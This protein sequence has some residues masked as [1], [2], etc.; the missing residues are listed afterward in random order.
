MWAS[1][2]SIVAC[3]LQSR[4]WGVAVASKF[5]A[6]G[7]LS[8]WAEPEVGAI[9]TQ[10]W[11]RAA[12]GE[13]GLELLRNGYSAQDTVQRLVNADDGRDQRQVG[14]VD[15]SGGAASHT[16]ARC[17]AA[18]HSRLGEGYAAQGNLLA[19][20]E[21]IDAMAETFES[22]ADR[23]F[24]MR[25][26][27]CVDAAQAKGGD[28]RGQQAASLRVVRQGGGYGE[29]NVSVDLRVD[30]HEQPLTE[31]RRL[32]D[33]H[34]LYFGST[35]DEEWL[36]VD[37]G[38]HDE[39]RTALEGLGYASGDLVEDLETWAGV[40]NLEERVSGVDR[41]DPIVL[42]ELKGRAGDLSAIPDR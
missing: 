13:E 40:E 10:G 3:D 24:P 9:A 38:L 31:L 7:A 17:L 8:A 36:V 11:I 37:E 34:G 12:Y 4:E 18:A 25:L 19:T 20:S 14:V 30:D 16:G 1:T 2:Y 39:L 26:L 33:L 5:L 23:P 15:R 42:A 6:I 29:A 41:I 22:T 35:P 28:R 21:A 32:Y 27:E